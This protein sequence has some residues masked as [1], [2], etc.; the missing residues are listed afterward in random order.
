MQKYPRICS[1][2]TLHG[3][4]NLPSACQGS[5]A[6]RREKEMSTRCQVK[7]T[8]KGLSWESSVML[9]H[10]WDGY[11]SN[12]VPL[13]RKAYEEGMK[14][15]NQRDWESERAW[16]MGRTGHAA[17]MLCYVDP[18]GFEPES[19]MELHGDIEYLYEVELINTNGG[20]LAERPTWI[21]RYTEDGEQ[22]QEILD[23]AVRV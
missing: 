11:P 15:V 2:N 20:S 12:M 1:L 18:R 13:I 21:I 7:V 23:S 6:L 19:G 14:P 8:Q 22:K 3:A 17:A 4:G 5:P 16:T 9:Y 10:H